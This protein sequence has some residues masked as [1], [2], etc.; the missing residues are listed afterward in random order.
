[1]NVRVHPW[2]TSFCLP[3]LAENRTKIKRSDLKRIGLLGCGGFGAVELWEHSKTGG[4]CALG[5]AH[6]PSRKGQ[7]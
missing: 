1:M 2:C 5:L 3:G 6:G 7:T 4:R